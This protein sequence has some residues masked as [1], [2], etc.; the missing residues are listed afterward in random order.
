MNRVLIEPADYGNVGLAIDRAFDCFPLPLAGRK[1][2][3][4]P[5]VLR[6]SE[7]REGIVTHPAVLKAV[8]QKV[9]AMNPAEEVQISAKLAFSARNP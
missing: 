9:L 3:I 6:A 4:K 7:A 8:V 2:L 5:N 1:I